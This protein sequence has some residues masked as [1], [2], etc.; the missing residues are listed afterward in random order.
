[1]NNRGS[2]WSTNGS[3]LTV[4]M[5][6]F[7][8]L[9]RS[10]GYIHWQDSG[11]SNQAR[12]ELGTAPLLKHSKA[13]IMQWQIVTITNLACV[14]YQLDLLST[15]LYLYAKC[16]ETKWKHTVLWSSSFDPNLWH[17][18]KELTWNHSLSEFSL[19]KCTLEVLRNRSLQMVGDDQPKTSNYPK[20]GASV[21]R[22]GW[23]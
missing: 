6:Q 17:K 10:K 23:V 13:M 12:L 22:D 20:P 21:D 15:W 11:W 5:Q 1:M 14:W 16:R 8:W 7:E 3:T 4:T 19:E 9:K 18:S 2:I